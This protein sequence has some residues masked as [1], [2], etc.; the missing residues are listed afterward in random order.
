MY[1]KKIYIEKKGK[2]YNQIIHMQFRVKFHVLILK[3]IAEF[4]SNSSAAAASLFFFFSCFSKVFIMALDSLSFLNDFL[5]FPHNYFFFREFLKIQLR[6]SKFENS[7]QAS[8][9]KVS[10]HPIG[11]LS[12]R[13]VRRPAVAA[14]AGNK[15]TRGR[16]RGGLTH[17]QVGLLVPGFS[18]RFNTPGERE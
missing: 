6:M 2:L 15:E 8:V 4:V 17:N 18:P 10:S 7:L 12:Q 16:R 11:H 1:Q 5:S 9:S 14:A 3:I 13:E